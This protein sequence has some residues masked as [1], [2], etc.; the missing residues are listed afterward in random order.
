MSAR[1]VQYEEA[2]RLLRSQ[3]IWDVEL[4]DWAPN[5]S[6]NDTQ[7]ALLTSIAPKDVEAALEAV[8]LPMAKHA[9]PLLLRTI[10]WG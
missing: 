1:D 4:I 9:R 3:G 10:Y 2:Y 7:K 6:S 5:P 8:G